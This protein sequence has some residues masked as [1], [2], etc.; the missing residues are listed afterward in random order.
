MKLLDKYFQA[1]LLLVFLG[2]LGSV[3]A[4]EGEESPEDYGEL[5][6]SIHNFISS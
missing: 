4:S 6:F 1:T 5:P 2:I 3:F